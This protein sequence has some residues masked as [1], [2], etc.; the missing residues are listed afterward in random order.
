VLLRRGT[1]ELRI[2]GRYL[3]MHGRGRLEAERVDPV[4]RLLAAMCDNLP[5]FV[6]ADRGVE[7][8][9]LPRP[10]SHRGAMTWPR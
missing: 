4:L 3:V 10:G 1:P 8:P 9:P 5:T 7:R 6:W 2:H